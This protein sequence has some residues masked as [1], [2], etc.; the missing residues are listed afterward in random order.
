M[1][2]SLR[3]ARRALTSS[4]SSNS[5]IYNFHT[6]TERC[7]HA[8]G[9]D[10][11][12]IK[13]SIEAGIKYLGFSDHA[14]CL[15]PHGFDDFYR[16]PYD[17]AESY[18]SDLRLLREKYKKDIQISIGL[19]M[20]Y[21]P[22]YFDEMLKTS[23]NIGAEYLILGQHFLNSEYPD[24]I[25]AAGPT[26]NDEVL[27][28]YVDEV[29]EAMKTGVF[30]Y[31]AHPDLTCF[32][33]DAEVYDREIRRLCLAAKK[34]DT[35]LEINLAGIRYNKHYPCDAFWKIAGETHAPVTIGY[36]AH[37]SEDMLNT[38]QLIKSAELISRY[39]LNYIG[40]PRLKRIR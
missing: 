38:D 39:K 18:V 9:S 36:D 21:Y 29:I 35:P 12:Y 2:F 16:V 4:F 13:C 37:R 1:V 24:G 8:S 28:L 14:P 3:E 5:M 31:L 30:T 33:G 40:M 11:D 20:E 22:L 32:T 25:G 10:E 26:D 15:F 34:Y 7:G 19:E 23:R 6:H 27:S 17:R